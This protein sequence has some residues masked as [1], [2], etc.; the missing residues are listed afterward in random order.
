M[1]FYVRNGKGTTAVVPPDANL[2][3]YAGQ[4]FFVS[5]QVNRKKS[6][7]SRKK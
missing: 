2:M 1:Y 7:F 5:D 4:T 3:D 6:L